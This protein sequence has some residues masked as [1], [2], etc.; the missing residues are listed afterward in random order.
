MNAEAAATNV[1]FCILT[2]EI[3]DF[4]R[5][6]QNAV[7]TE[8]AMLEWLE[9]GARNAFLPQ[10]EPAIHINVAFSPH[11]PPLQQLPAWW[12]TVVTM[13]PD[14]NTM[15]APTRIDINTCVIMSVEDVHDDFAGAELLVLDLDDNPIDAADMTNNDFTQQLICSSVDWAADAV[16]PAFVA[17][18]ILVVNRPHHDAEEE[19]E[20]EDDD[21][22]AGE[23]GDNNDMEE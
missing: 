17:G 6:L 20:Q 1:E 9:A 7:N 22:A 21:E 14:I 18:D 5:S 3:Q 16:L 15:G 4:Q 19:E 12:P 23:D 11:M 10:G 2:G 13:F 8:D